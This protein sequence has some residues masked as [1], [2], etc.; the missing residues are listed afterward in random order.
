MDMKRYI[1]LILLVTVSA[2][3]QNEPEPV[4][5][6]DISKYTGRWFNVSS[7]AVVPL[8]H[9]IADLKYF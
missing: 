7:I 9:E 8:F 2:S 4:S 1:D 6:I 5:E 3:V